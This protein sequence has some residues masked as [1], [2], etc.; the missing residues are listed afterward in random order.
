MKF[1][2]TRHAQ[3][4]ALARQG[5]G[6]AGLVGIGADFRVFDW[7][8]VGFYVFRGAFAP[9]T[10]ISAPCDEISLVHRL[11]FSRSDVAVGGSKMY[12]YYVASPFFFSV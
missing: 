11:V 9:E 5:A 3:T 7:R 6:T 8:S 2:R 10:D 12:L 1:L 4:A